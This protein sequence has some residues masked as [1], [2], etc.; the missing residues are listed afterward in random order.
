MLQKMRA[1]IDF[2]LSNVIFVRCACA[3]LRLPFRCASAS[4]LITSFRAQCSVD[5]EQWTIRTCVKE[6]WSQASNCGCAQTNM[7]LSRFCAFCG[8]LFSVSVQMTYHQ[9]LSNRRESVRWQIYSIWVHWAPAECPPMSD[10]NGRGHFLVHANYNKPAI[11]VGNTRKTHRHHEWSERAN[12]RKMMDGRSN[13]AV[14]VCALPLYPLVC[15]DCCSRFSAL[16]W[17]HKTHIWS[18]PHGRMWNL[19]ADRRDRLDRRFRCIANKSIRRNSVDTSFD[20]RRRGQFYR[21]EQRIC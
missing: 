21:F 10:R 6:K 2:A 20:W 1:R 14:M 15:V 11:K 19:W 16:I 9:G 13:R 17:C 4:P 18:S 7:P 3:P 5:N 8:G 12:K